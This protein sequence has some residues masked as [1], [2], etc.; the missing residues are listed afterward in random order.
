MVSLPLRHHE[1]R[2]FAAASSSDIIRLQLLLMDLLGD[3]DDDDDEV[4]VLI[5]RWCKFSLLLPLLMK[6][7]SL[8]RDVSRLIILIKECCCTK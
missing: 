2:L 8:F 6:R 7:G 4:L 1:C 3:D 5:I